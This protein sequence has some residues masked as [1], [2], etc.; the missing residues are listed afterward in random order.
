MKIK[1]QST[2]DND[3][4]EDVAIAVMNVKTENGK[5]VNGKEAWEAVKETL[6]KIYKGIE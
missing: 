6:D 3:S 1:H 2:G 5:I 4:I